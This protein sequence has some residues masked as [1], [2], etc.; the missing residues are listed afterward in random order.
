VC[1]V[2]RPHGP[3]GGCGDG[4]QPEV[5]LAA[6]GSLQ[7][8]W[9]MQTRA[10]PASSSLLYRFVLSLSFSIYLSLNPFLSDELIWCRSLYQLSGK[11]VHVK[12]LILHIFGSSFGM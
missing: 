1:L 5:V 8:G 2:L 7:P 6:A 4:R 10:P 3:V 11:E 12:V 9:R